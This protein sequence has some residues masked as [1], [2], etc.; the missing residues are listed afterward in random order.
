MRISQAVTKKSRKPKVKNDVPETG[1]SSNNK[2]VITTANK[3][4]KPNPR[5]NT[6]KLRTEEKHATNKMNFAG[7]K[8]AEIGKLKRKSS[9]PN[10]GDVKKARI[11]KQ[12]TGNSVPKKRF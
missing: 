10:R 1:Q 4:S 9:K 8:I 11:A 7:D 5:S 6:W 2:V 3:R 12:L